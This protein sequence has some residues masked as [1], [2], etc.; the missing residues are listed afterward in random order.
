M[1]T[2]NGGS[3]TTIPSDA[4]EI[5]INDLSFPPQ[6]A[7]VLGIGRSVASWRRAVPAVGMGASR[8]MVG[9]DFVHVAD[10]YI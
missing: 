9:R 7:F 8:R 4:A 2:V 1:I 3:E 5:P 10:D 6:T